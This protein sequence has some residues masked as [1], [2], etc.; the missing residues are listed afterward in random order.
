MSIVRAVLR[1]GR[2][3]KEQNLLRNRPDE[4]EGHE[5]DWLAIEMTYGAVHKDG[6][7]FGF[8]VRGPLF[9]D[10]LDINVSGNGGRGGRNAT[11][12]NS[13][14]EFDDVVEEKE[15]GRTLICTFKGSNSDELSPEHGGEKNLRS[16][17]RWLE[18]KNVLGSS[19]P[20]QPC[21]AEKM[22]Y[23]RSRLA[24]LTSQSTTNNKSKG[25][26]DWGDRLVPL[27]RQAQ[28]LRT[29]IESSTQILLAH[30][31]I[32][33]RWR[34]TRSMAFSLNIV[35]PSSV[36][37]PAPHLQ[38]AH[39]FLRQ[40]DTNSGNR[41]ATWEVDR[42]SLEAVLSLWNWSIISDPKLEK[43]DEAGLKIS[44]ASE[45]ATARVIATG[46]TQTEL[47]SAQ[48]E[49]ENWWDD[50]SL[51]TTTQIRTMK[52][53]HNSIGASTVW[54]K[55]YGTEILEPLS[56]HGPFDSTREYVRLFEIVKQSLDDGS[57]V[58]SEDELKRTP[59]SY[60]AEHGHDDV[61]R[62]L[63]Q[64]EALPDPI[65]YE[66]RKPLSCVSQGDHTSVMDLLL[67]NSEAT[68]NTGDE[69]G[70]TPSHWAAAY[71]KQSSVKLLTSKSFGTDIDIRDK[72]HRTPL[73]V[74]LVNYRE[75]AAEQLLA[76]AAKWDFE[77]GQH[78]AW[79]WAFLN[80]H[81]SCGKFL[82]NVVNRESNDWEWPVV[83]I[84][85]IPS[86][87]CLLTQYHMAY[88]QVLFDPQ[89]LSGQIVAMCEMTKNGT[90]LLVTTA[91]ILLNVLGRPYHYEIWVYEFD[92]GRLRDR[93][94]VESPGRIWL[95]IVR[96]L[97]KSALSGRELREMLQLL[98]DRG[99]DD[100]VEMTGQ[101]CLQ[102]VQTSPRPGLSDREL[103]DMLQL[104]LDRGGDDFVVSHKL[105][106]VAA[107]NDTLV[108]STLPILLNRDWQKIPFTTGILKECMRLS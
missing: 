85:R 66:R 75:E 89:K 13:S 42:N 92:Q 40:P 99:G 23:Y 31:G 102:I 52:P 77:I 50:L 5:L 51:F 41:S 90:Q 53:G 35:V 12:R 36:N 60:A 88:G 24:E 64:H 34:E 56:E 63:M 94:G 82:L 16:E 33:P 19:Q 30:A 95:E 100:F 1:T 97:P 8:L 32:K 27:R 86:E 70:W 38:Q 68:A 78:K 17:A 76:G 25:P 72:C 69:D 108:E 9:Q 54:K 65:D 93:A 10:G 26:A 96:S 57:Q 46:A 45:V 71:G 22:F 47:K 7:T 91:Q 87:F 37:S 98:H 29:A 84:L 43:E 74:A 79:K 59:L 67:K 61:I 73:I 39:I 3:K 6:G 101:M 103:G 2:L 11:A 28:Q 80:G 4:V 81:W 44:L 14:S 106:M 21:T 55:A 105:V 48:A 104:L 20:P 15:S 62:I 58:D 83:T 18:A 107:K 49:L